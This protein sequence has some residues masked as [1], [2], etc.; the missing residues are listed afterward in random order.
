M[1][2]G[3]SPKWMSVVLWLAAVYNLLWGGAA[4]LFPAVFF[5]AAGMEPPEYLWL[6]QCVGMIVGVYGI[7]YGCA[8]LDPARHWPI[9][10]VGL[11]GKV[12]GPI[13]FAQALWLRE[14]T[15][16]FGIN[17]IFNDLIWWV[18]FAL[19]LVHAWKRAKRMESE[20]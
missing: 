6:W 17:I 3:G 20:A 1:T 8:A 18:P 11:L 5:T 12:F 7:G 13:G 4:V 19:I 16:A 15:P 9:V 2:S 10:L 14:I